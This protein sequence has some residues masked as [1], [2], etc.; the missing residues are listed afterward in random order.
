MPSATII[1]IE[2]IQNYYLWKY[3]QDGIEHSQDKN[4]GKINEKLLFHGTSLT[5]PHKIYQGEEGFDTKFSQSG[6]W[7]RG[8]Y[9][10]SKSSYSDKFA[11]KYKDNKGQLSGERGIFLAL[12]NL[13]EEQFIQYDENV[14]R[15]MIEPPQNKDSVKGSTNGSDVYVVYANKKAYPHYYI[16]YKIKQ[17]IEEAKVSS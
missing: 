9:F 1:S 12:V 2:L 6:M 8:L 16:R 13:G 7:G 17:Q 15:K 14:T 11:F 3:Y 10:A 5:D 4:F